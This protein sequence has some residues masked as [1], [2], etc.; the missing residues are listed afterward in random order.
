M[1]DICLLNKIWGQDKIYILVGT[2]LGSNMMLALFHNFNFTKAEKYVIHQLNFMSSQF[3]R[4][5]SVEGFV[6]FIK[7]FKA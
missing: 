3:T 2:L 4:I 5:Y 1:I 6:K 7:Y